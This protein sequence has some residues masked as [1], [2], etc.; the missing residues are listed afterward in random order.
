MNN[1]TKREQFA[2]MAMQG[3]LSN[4]NCTLTYE[5]ITFYSVAMADE[6]ARGLSIIEANDLMLF[7]N[8]IKRNNEDV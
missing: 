2:A 8:K 6:L 3:F 1:L 5:Q 4:S 7:K